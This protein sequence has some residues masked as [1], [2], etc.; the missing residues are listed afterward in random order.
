M[1][2][3]KE[4]LL[5]NEKLLT[6]ENCILQKRL[7]LKTEQSYA[8]F[9]STKIIMGDSSTNMFVLKR[10]ISGVAFDVS[11]TKRHII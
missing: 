8:T 10:H 3:D 11:R 1:I 4:C 7:Y 5:I 9:F 2:H 6:Y